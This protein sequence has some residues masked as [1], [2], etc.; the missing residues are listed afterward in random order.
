MWWPGPGQDLYSSG[1]TIQAY[2]QCSAALWPVTHLNGISIPA[3]NCPQEGLPRK[4]LRL[5]QPRVS[6]QQGLQQGLQAV[7]LLSEVLQPGS[8]GLCQVGNYCK[9]SWPVFAAQPQPAQSCSP[10]AFE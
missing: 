8:Q 6:L 2:Q 9:G 10:Y 7:K 5:Q 1:V 3:L 4:P